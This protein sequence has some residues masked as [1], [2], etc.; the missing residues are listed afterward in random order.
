LK[1]IP[2]LNAEKRLVSG[3]YLHNKTSFRAQPESW[4]KES[5]ARKDAICS[6]TTFSNNHVANKE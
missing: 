5:S 1:A 3:V 4:V 2:R 6:R